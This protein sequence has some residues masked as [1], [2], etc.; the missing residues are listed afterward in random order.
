MQ[1][2]K[3]AQDHTDKLHARTIRRFRMTNSVNEGTEGSTGSR[4]EQARVGGKASAKVMLD[5]L[6]LLIERE[7]EASNI[8]L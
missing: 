1:I 2:A 5:H 4:P 8:R 6:I 3:V 7:I